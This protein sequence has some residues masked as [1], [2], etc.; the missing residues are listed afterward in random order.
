MIIYNFL[1]LV[2]IFKNIE[3]YNNFIWTFDSP[4]SHCAIAKIPDITAIRFSSVIGFP[5]NYTGNHFFFLELVPVALF[6]GAEEPDDGEDYVIVGEGRR[7]VEGDPTQ[8]SRGVRDHILERDFITS[9][10]M[11]RKNKVCIHPTWTS[12]D[13]GFLSH[14]VKTWSVLAMSSPSEASKGKFITSS[15]FSLPVGNSCLAW[16]TTVKSAQPF[17]LSH[18][19]CS[20]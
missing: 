11:E 5:L 17:R 19:C 10:Y 18:L 13:C 9:V 6:L 7:V 3:F 15:L 8:G 1:L 16:P 12:C 14:L 4:C 2:L 20:Q